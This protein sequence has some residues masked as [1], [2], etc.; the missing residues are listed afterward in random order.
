MCVAHCFLSDA[1]SLVAS[2]LSTPEKKTASVISANT[3]KRHLFTR[4]WQRHLVVILIITGEKL[5]ARWPWHKVHRGEEVEV[6]RWV[7]KTSHFNTRDRWSLPV[8]YQPHIYIPLMSRLRGDGRELQP[9]ALYWRRFGSRWTHKGKVLVIWLYTEDWWDNDRQMCQQVGIMWTGEQVDVGVW[10]ESHR[11]S[12]GQV[13]NGRCGEISEMHGGP[14]GGS[15][16]GADWTKSN[17]YDY[18][19]SMF[20][21]ENYSLESYMSI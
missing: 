7:N 19:D 17:H 20:L 6:H 9:S 10:W 14:E 18:T 15:D 2:S 11:T 1:C 21:T 3:P 12:G 16:E 4:N 8:S 5:E 13:E